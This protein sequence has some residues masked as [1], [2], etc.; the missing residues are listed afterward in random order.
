MS[1]DIARA[2]DGVATTIRH[3]EQAGSLMGRSGAA[4]GTAMQRAETVLESLGSGPEFAPQRAVC[5]EVI[6]ELRD[7][8]K[9][10]RE[11]E[12][13]LQALRLRMDHGTTGVY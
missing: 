6:A 9:Q 2:I 13:R 4:I 12:L 5:E 11:N 7:Q 10:A 1:V 3:M 8:A